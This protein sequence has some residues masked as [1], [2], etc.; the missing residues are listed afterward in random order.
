MNTISRWKDKTLH[1]LLKLLPNLTG[2]KKCIRR[3]YI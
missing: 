3:C 1:L 2:D